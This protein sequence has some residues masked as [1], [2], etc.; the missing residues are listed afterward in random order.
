[1]KFTAVSFR[2]NGEIVPKMCLLNP[3]LAFL[4]NVTSSQK[5]KH[6]PRSNHQ[7]S[8]WQSGV[9]LFVCARVCPTELIT[10]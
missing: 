9:C 8:L 2:K 3:P 6:I 4:H 5:G 7:L 1:M 10:S